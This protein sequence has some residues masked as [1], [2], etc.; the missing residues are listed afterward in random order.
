LLRG[1]RSRL[2]HRVSSPRCINSV[3]IGS[4]ADTRPVLPSQPFHHHTT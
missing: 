4:E 3:A 2:A 1:I